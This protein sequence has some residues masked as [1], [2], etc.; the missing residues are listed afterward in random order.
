MCMSVYVCMSVCVLLSYVCRPMSC[1]CMCM[2]ICVSSVVYRV[3]C[4]IVLSYV[5]VAI[6]Y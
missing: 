2:F 3:L 6:R 4:Y 1:V 5:I